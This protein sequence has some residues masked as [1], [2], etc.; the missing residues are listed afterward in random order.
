MK[1]IQSF[2]FDV[3]NNSSVARYLERM[4]RV[5]GVDTLR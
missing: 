5:A 4:R 2:L 1:D 3:K